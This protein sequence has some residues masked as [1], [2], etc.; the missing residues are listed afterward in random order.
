MSTGRWSELS[1]ELEVRYTG[2]GTTISGI[3]GLLATVLTLAV[4][5]FIVFPG[6][7]V[8]AAAD[9][10]LGFLGPADF[11]VAVTLGCEGASVTVYGVGLGFGGG[12]EVALTTRPPSAQQRARPAGL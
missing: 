11:L 6:A 9:F 2:N 4:A 10:G 5:F 12:V 7:G 3:V 8:V 1:A